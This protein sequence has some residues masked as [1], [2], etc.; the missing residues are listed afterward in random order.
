MYHS[1]FNDLKTLRLPLRKCCVRGVVLKPIAED[2]IDEAIDSFRV[3]ILCSSFEVQGE[4]DKILVYISLWIQRCL[5]EADLC[6]KEMSRQDATFNHNLAHVSGQ[7]IKNLAVTL[8]GPSSNDFPPQ[9]VPFQYDADPDI[10]EYLRQV[11]L[12][13]WD[14][15]QAQLFE[16]GGCDRNKWWFQY[17]KKC[18]LNISL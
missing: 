1:Q 18:F 7:R 3:N 16:N 6:S 11:R 5:L 15:L 17:A 8:G 12:E 14:R 9:L 10:A 13:T 2:I 4:A